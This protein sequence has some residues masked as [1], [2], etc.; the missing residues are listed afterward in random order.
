MTLKAILSPR[1]GKHCLCYTRE[2]ETAA[3]A[4]VGVGWGEGLETVGLESR[5][6]LLMA[7]WFSNMLLN[8]LES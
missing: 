1:R 5:H 3:R 7:V 2:I 4:M 8:L 6:Q